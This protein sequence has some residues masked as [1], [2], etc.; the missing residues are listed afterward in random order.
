MERN[1]E[2]VFDGDRSGQHR[3]VLRTR[4]KAPDVKGWSDQDISPL[5]SV[6]FYK[7]VTSVLGE[8]K[9]SRSMRCSSFD[10]A[11]GTT[12]VNMLVDR[13]EAQHVR[14]LAPNCE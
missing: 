6:N 3:R 10:P 5:A 12:T 2:V 8:A 11:A 1:F 13:V 7:S 9:I 4:G 14:M